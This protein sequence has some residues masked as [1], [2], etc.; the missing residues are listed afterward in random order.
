M[1]K[2]ILVPLRKHEQI[3]K[4]IPYLKAFAEPSTHVVFL[5][6]QPVNG[7]KWLQAYSAIMQCGLEKTAAIRRMVES[8]STETRSQLAQ[9]RVFHAC[10]ALHELGLKIAVEAYT[11]SLREALKS[12]VP[13]GDVDLI[14]MRPRIATRAIELL[15]QTVASWIPFKRPPVFVGTQS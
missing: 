15:H 4:I 12:F 13:G 2:K 9:R 7:F 3:E 10:E 5:V 1:A 6:H 14:I 11:G 8:Y